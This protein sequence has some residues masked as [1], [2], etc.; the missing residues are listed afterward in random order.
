[1]TLTLTG[2]AVESTIAALS[3]ANHEFDKRYP[4]EA[5]TRQPVHSVYGG[6]QRFRAD[7]VIK[8][9]AIARDTLRIYAP[10]PT[11]LARITGMDVPVAEPVHA[12]IAAKLEREPIEDFRIDLEDGYGIH[13]GAEEDAHATEAAGQLARAM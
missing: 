6:A 13:T 11:A 12:R 1:M 8:L 10:D 9:G 3:Q 7:T 5:T 2:D 4:G